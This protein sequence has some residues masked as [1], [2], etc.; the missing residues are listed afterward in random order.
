MT[1]ENMKGC[2]ISTLKN[3]CKSVFFFFL[4]ISL[5][6]AIFA[7]LKENLRCVLNI[8]SSFLS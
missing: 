5:I 3:Q 8:P 6:I 7:A 1:K 2:L 4:F